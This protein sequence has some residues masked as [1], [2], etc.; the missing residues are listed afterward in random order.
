MPAALAAHEAVAVGVE[1][2]RGLLGLVVARGHRLHRAEAGDGERHDDRLGAARD[3]DVGVAALDELGRRRRWRG[4]RW[5]RR[6][7][8]TEFGPLGAEAHRDEARRHVDDQHRD[9]EGRDAVGPLARAA[10][11]ALEQRGDAADAGADEHAEAGAV[12]LA[13]CRARRPPPPSRAQAM[14]YL[15]VRDRA[16]ARPSCR[17]T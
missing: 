2:P 16:V 1:R 13:R 6:S 3:H 14:A 12:H 11:V 10:S 15:Q 5:R 9:E 4:C 8:P 7:R 17:R